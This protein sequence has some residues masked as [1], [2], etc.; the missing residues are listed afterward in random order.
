[1]MNMCSRLMLGTVQFGG[2]YGV[3]NST[4]QVTVSEMKSILDLAYS[5]NISKLDTANDYGNSEE[6]LGEYN[7]TGWQTVSKLNSIPSKAVDYNNYIDQKVKT[8]LSK[9][10]IK[11]LEGLLLHDA[12]NISGSKGQL[13]YKGLINQKIKGQVKK[14]GISTYD[15]EEACEIAEKFKIDIVQLPYNIFDQRLIRTG[16]LKRLKELRVEVHIRSIFLQGL[17]LMPKDSRPKYHMRWTN[18]LG[19]WDT[20]KTEN[21]LSPLQACL[22]PA[23]QYKEIDSILI[24]IQN[25]EQLSQIINIKSFT[26]P[27]LP[28][29]L[30]C[31]DPGLI[32]PSLWKE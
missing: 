22:A 7:I 31:N 11:S 3:S 5:H 13:V 4:G 28:E 16:S 15:P 32:N 24:G 10:K 25:K 8:C 17:L 20:W 2:D 9:L 23:L 21:N 12:G 1:M 6:R 29:S 14:I 30:Y 27:P 26:I 18:Y 19:K